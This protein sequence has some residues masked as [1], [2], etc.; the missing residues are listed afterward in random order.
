MGKVIP[1]QEQFRMD[2]LF[3]EKRW[4]QLLV[5]LPPDKTFILFDN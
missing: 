1:K 4:L 5:E 2:M 3:S